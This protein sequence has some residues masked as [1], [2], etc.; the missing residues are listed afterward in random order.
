L[1]ARREALARLAGAC[2]F[3]PAAIVDASLC[4]LA[5]AE[6]V[7][8]YLGARPG[9]PEPLRRANRQSLAAGI[10]RGRALAP[11]SGA[12]RS[13]GI[14]MVLL[15]GAALDR[16]VYAPGERSMADVDILVPPARFGDAVAAAL[17]LGGRRIEPEGRA[18]SSR[19]EY[20]IAVCLP[21]GVEV[22]IHRALS[23]A[24]LYAVDVDG[25]CG[26]AVA[27]PDGVAT[28]EPSD[29][30]VTLG[31]HAA[32]HGFSVPFRSILDGLLVATRLDVDFS[33]VAARARMYRARRATA[34]WLRVLR[35]FG[36]A[37]AG[38]DVAL[39]DLGGDAAV[40]WLADGAPWPAGATGWRRA[41]RI[42]ALAEGVRAPG[43]LLWRGALRVADTIT[44][45]I[46]ARR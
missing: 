5:E 15:K 24:P 46:H 34:A 12:L 9:A 28:P 10:V 25:V 37:D 38:A 39:A 26:R 27:G 19:L 41:A 31:V 18:V 35:R 44:G 45:T 4:A 7:A 33:A 22:E 6:G 13:A 20:A 43:W 36:L 11:L 8:A 3:G 30:F 17:A 40:R 1:S 14:P 16:L 2:G 21:G 29:L 42:A 32:K 23:S